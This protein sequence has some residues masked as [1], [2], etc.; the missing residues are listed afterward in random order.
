M[1]KDYKK[2]RLEFRY[3]D[4]FIGSVKELI[5]E[6]EHLHKK[7]PGYDDF[8]FEEHIYYP[9]APTAYNLYGIRKETDKERDKRLAKV[10]K[11]RVSQ[12]KRREKEAKEKEARERR[13]YKKLKAKFEKD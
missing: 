11:A 13:T 2:V 8:T 9:D 1:N 7:H 4:F 10:K 12:R 5:K 6:L 3:P